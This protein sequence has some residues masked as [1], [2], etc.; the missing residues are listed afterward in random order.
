M[1]YKN[2]VGP[3]EILISDKNSNEILRQSLRSNE[4]GDPRDTSFSWDLKSKSN[5][6]VESG[7]YT[8]VLIDASKGIECCSIKCRVVDTRKILSI[9]RSLKHSPTLSATPRLFSIYFEMIEDI[10]LAILERLE[11]NRFEEP[12]FVACITICF[13]Q[14]I[15]DDLKNQSKSRFLDQMTEFQSKNSISEKTARL[16][17]WTLFDFL[18]NYMADI[19]DH[20]R[21]NAMAKCGQ[22]YL[23]QNDK[24]Q[25]VSSLVL[26]IYPHC[27]TMSLPNNAVGRIAEK[28][29]EGIIKCGIRYVSIKHINKSISI[30]QSLPLG[31]PYNVVIR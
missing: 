12:F 6:F 9:T 22:H 26:A 15:A 3:L 29:A 24:A 2:K 19:E 20:V 27:K 5:S 21:A 14:E 8:I 30:C 23:T 13:I 18:I 16:G 31:N 10:Q 28:I 25:I 17:L 1:E 4:S 11:D 7:C